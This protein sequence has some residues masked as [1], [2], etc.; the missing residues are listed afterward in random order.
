[1]F[2]E[3][4]VEATRVAYVIDFSGSMRG[5]REKLMRTELSKSVSQLSPMM[6]FQLI[7][8]SGPVWL[9]GDRVKMDPENKTGV[10]THGDTEYDWERGKE[11]GSWV[12]KGK[13]PRADWL[14]ADANAIK[15]AVRHI[16]ETPLQYGTHWV[17]PLEMALEMK[18]PPD[19]IFFMTDGASPGTT[20]QD[21]KRL[22]SKARARNT[23]INTMAM[24]EP[25][26]EG[27]MKDLAR[28]CHGQFTIINEN[29]SVKV[30][31]MD[32]EKKEEKVERTTR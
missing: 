12:Y 23:I 15:E 13:K 16:E 29:G 6:Q 30:V 10:V 22:G 26:A 4:K 18:P 25:A 3:Q 31:P 21:I 1:M 27:P 24:M 7:F 9:A 28:L 2:F 32:P 19:V 11:P 20:E 17:A 8:F 14:P 5:K